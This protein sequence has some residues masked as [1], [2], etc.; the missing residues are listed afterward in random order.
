M[1]V[2][3]FI[4]G[5]ALIAISSAASAEGFRGNVGAVSEY[6]F[7][8]VEG[9]QGAAVQGELYY[10]WDSGLYAGGWITNAREASN[11]VDAYVGY[12]TRIGD[13]AVGGGVVYR[14]YSE[15]A[16]HG[17]LNPAGGEID[18]PEVFVTAAIGPAS[19]TAYF[20][21]DYFGTDGEALYVTGDV[22]MAL[23]DT[24]TLIGQA[25]FNSG[26]GVENLR[27]EEYTDYSVSIEKKLE[28]EMTVMFQVVDTDREFA[29]GLDD[30]PK[31]VVG[32]RKDF[33]L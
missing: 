28:R 3:K 16:E 2:S 13:F 10:S 22:S 24:V 6:L 33:A 31:F 4:A 9:S 17:T 32:L 23:A 25:G 20:A 29:S 5:A 14:Y 1:K 30:D 8:G 27:G 7:R 15:D 18:F 11:K 26:D 12:E 19:L 21:D